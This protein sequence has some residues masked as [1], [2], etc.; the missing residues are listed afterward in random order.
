MRCQGRY[1]KDTPGQIEEQA[2]CDLIGMKVVKEFEKAVDRIFEKFGIDFQF[3]KHF[4]ERLSDNRNK[5]CIRMQ[6]LA[7]LIK[8][9]YKRQGKSL[10]NVAGA[11]AVIKDLQS[12]LNMPVAVKYDKKNDEF[13]VVAK[14]IMRKKNF[15]TPDEV[16]SY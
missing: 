2:S 4:A 12:D 3:T 16:I 13:D 5:P 6:E 1:R 11:E 8:K 14:T 7:D 9:I 15:H 10:K